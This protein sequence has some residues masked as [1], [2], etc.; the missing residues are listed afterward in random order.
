VILAATGNTA[1]AEIFLEPVDLAYPGNLS[2]TFRRAAFY[3]SIGALPQASRTGRR[4]SWRIPAEYRKDIPLPVYALMYPLH[5]RDI[6]TSE[7]VQRNIDPCFVF[8]VIRQES[9]FNP[10]AV[11]SAGAIGLMQMMPLTGAALARELGKP[12]SVD[13]L[14]RP[15]ANIRY[16]TVYLRK[17][18]DQFNENDVLALASYN[19][20]PPNAREWYIRNRDKDLDLFIEDIDFSETRNYVKRVLANYWFYRRLIRIT[21]AGAECQ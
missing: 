6:I 19:G 17:L 8:A 9:V 3:R 2:L 1:D 14:Y 12:F 21:P 18:L 4:L 16:G 7:A 5:Y 15:S 13:T 20:G 10:D 11:S